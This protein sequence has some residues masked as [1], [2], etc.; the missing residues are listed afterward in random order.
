MFGWE[1]PPYISGGLGTASYGITRGLSELGVEVIFVLPQVKEKSVDI[2]V[3]LLSASEVL[4]TETGPIETTIGPYVSLDFRLGLD[5]GDGKLTGEYGPDLFAQV[6][7]YARAA[8][9]IAEKEEFEVIHGHDWTSV[10]AC[11]KVKAKTGKPYIY[12]VHALEFDRSGENVNPLVY[13]IEKYGLQR[14]DRIIAVS[15]YTKNMIVYRYG[16]NPGRIAVVHNAVTQKEGT[17]F[18]RIKKDEKRKLVLFLG[19]ITFQ[20]GPDYFVEAANLVIKSIP[21][22]HFI[23]AGTGDMLPRMIERV[24]E[25][26]ISRYFSFPGFLRGEEVERMYA[27]SDLYVMPSVSEP[28]GI[29]PLEAMLYDVP[30]IISKQSGVAE[31]LHHAIKVDFWDVQELAHKMIALLSYPVVA[32]EMTKNAREE[33][34]KLRWEKAAAKIIALYREVLSER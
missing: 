30:V 25:L 11:T 19:R 4:L 33:L 6:M 12:H 3:R 22:V 17:E 16:I 21:H 10:L 27:L 28:F 7:R 9:R 20:K 14:A 8:V 26:G 2:P 29:S 1:F 23:M 15:Y 34:K 32:E 18:L 13:E 31:V 24:A 5:K